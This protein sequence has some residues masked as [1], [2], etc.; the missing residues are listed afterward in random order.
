MCPYYAFN[1]LLQAFPGESQVLLSR[2]KMV[3][4]HSKYL[5]GKNKKMRN[6]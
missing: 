4:T 6:F 5:R 3:N 1:H 2:V